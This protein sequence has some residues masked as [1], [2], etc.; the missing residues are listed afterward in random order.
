MLCMMYVLYSTGTCKMC[1]ALRLDR[2]LVAR[3]LELAPTY[4]HAHA[5][6]PVRSQPQWIDPRDFRTA[7][8]R[9]GGPKHANTMRIHALR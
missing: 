6:G 1:A 5:A 3:P 9:G 8:V 4:A 7:L 2:E